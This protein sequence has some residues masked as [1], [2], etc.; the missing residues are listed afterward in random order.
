M[1]GEDGRFQI[2]PAGSR[3]RAKVREVNDGCHEWGGHLNHN[4]YGT[5]WVDGRTVPAH[6]WAYEQVHGPVPEGLQIDH[7][8]RN[9]RCV[10]P[11]HLEA[12]TGRENLLRGRTFQAAN[13]AKDACP[14]GHP[15][16]GVNSK[17]S[18]TCRTCDREAWLRYYYSKGK[19]KRQK[20]RAR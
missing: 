2:V 12:V 14:K 18:R 19:E 6:R 4:G 10:N 17:G 11:A 3:F 1:R 15:Y 7:L 8:C 9:P 16:D 5:F 13:A 20:K